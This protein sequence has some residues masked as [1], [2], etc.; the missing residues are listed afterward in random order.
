MS[1]KYS[2]G[3]VTRLGLIKNNKGEPYRHKETILKLIQRYFPTAERRR[4]AHGE[5][6]AIT[7]KMIAK[8]NRRW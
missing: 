7:E 2:L 8:L 4:T 6:Y 3:E 5:G 1:L